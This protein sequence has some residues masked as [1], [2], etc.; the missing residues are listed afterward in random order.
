M[1]SWITK[2]CD[3]DFASFFFGP[4]ISDAHN[5]APTYANYW[6]W[7]AHRA[8][9]PVRIPD[10]RRLTGDE[11]YILNSAGWRQNPDNDFNRILIW[12]QVPG[13]GDL[14]G[15][16]PAFPQFSREA[17]VVSDRPEQRADKTWERTQISQG[18]HFYLPGVASSV[19]QSLAGMLR[20]VDSRRVSAACRG[21]EWLWWGDKV[22][23]DTT[24][25]ESDPELQFERPGGGGT[26]QFRVMRIMNDYDLERNAW[27]SKLGVVDQPN[28]SALR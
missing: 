1:L 13:Q 5:V 2:L 3:A 25:P 17:F 15:L 14:G 9:Y 8:T 10:A 4:S 20:D 22:W 19:A 11:N 16:M 6:Q 28:T 7:L 23:F 24:G 26:Q 21:I 27:G 18:P 12:G